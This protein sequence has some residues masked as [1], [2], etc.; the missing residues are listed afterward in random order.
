M[1]VTAKGDAQDHI[2]ELETSQKQRDRMNANQT[3]TEVLRYPNTGAE[4]ESQ[5][6]PSPEKEGSL[7]KVMDMTVVPNAVTVK[8]TSMEKIMK[9]ASG[10]QPT[11][12]LGE[13]DH[14]AHGASSNK[15]VTKKTD[16]G[17]TRKNS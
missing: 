11:H 2:R 7:M 1:A 16:P 15:K 6:C 17:P 10:N 5:G 13:E 12:L 4:E 14:A 3:T 9:G 8:G